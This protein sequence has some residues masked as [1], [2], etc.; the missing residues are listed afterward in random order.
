MKNKLTIHKDGATIRLHNKR[1]SLKEVDGTIMVKFQF[2][3]ENAEKS[4]CYHKCY[5]GKIRETFIKMSDEVIEALLFA[6]V[7]YKRH[8]AKAKQTD[9]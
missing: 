2:A 7:N 5:K 1:I 4:A 9:V 6:Y 8:C 3:D